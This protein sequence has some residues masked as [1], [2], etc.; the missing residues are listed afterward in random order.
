MISSKNDFDRRIKEGEKEFNHRTALKGL[1][2]EAL[3]LKAHALISANQDDELKTTMASFQR[4]ADDADKNYQMLNYRN[5]LST[6]SYGNAMKILLGLLGGE[7]DNGG[8]YPSKELLWKF[9]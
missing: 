5:A 6:E 2:V 8:P 4:W 3:H 1:L 7:K 9:K